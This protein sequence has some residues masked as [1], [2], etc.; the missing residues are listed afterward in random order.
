MGEDD[1]IMKKVYAM[2]D[3]SRDDTEFILKVARRLI[4]LE[5]RFDDSHE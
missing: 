1:R 2:L 3:D 5:E 4:E